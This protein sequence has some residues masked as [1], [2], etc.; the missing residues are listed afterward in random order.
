M[1][2][3]PIY[4]YGVFVSAVI[5]KYCYVQVLKWL[6][7]PL[8]DFRTLKKYYSLIFFFFLKIPGYIYIYI[9]VKEL[10]NGHVPDSIWIDYLLQK[11]IWLNRLFATEVNLVNHI[12][13]PTFWSTG[14][15]CGLVISSSLHFFS[16]GPSFLFIFSFYFNHYL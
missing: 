2:G 10:Q 12:H 14:F 16:Y 8:Y 3:Q 1:I 5:L 9:Y 6:S 7:T 4:I 15:E 13:E 11:L